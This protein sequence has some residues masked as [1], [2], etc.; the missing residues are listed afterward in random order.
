LHALFVWE[1][2]YFFFAWSSATRAGVLH[3][4]RVLRLHTGLW[5]Q[6]LYLFSLLAQ[7]VFTFL[8]LLQKKS[9]KRKRESA[10]MTAA[11]DVGL[12][13]LQYYC[14]DKLRKSILVGASAKC[15]E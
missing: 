13:K 2:L 15:V 11:A 14:S 1:N 3:T 4:L 10:A 12:I 5:G 9:N 8:L 6:A 7:R